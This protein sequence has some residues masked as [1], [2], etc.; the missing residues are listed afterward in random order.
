[1]SSLAKGVTRSSQDQVHDV[2]QSQVDVQED[3]VKPGGHCQGDG[4]V[5]PL[6]DV[7]DDVQ[8]LGAR[9][10]Q[11]EVRQD[12]QQG[13]GDSLREAQKMFSEIESSGSTNM[14]NISCDG[15]SVEQL[16]MMGVAELQCKVDLS[17]KNERKC[18]CDIGVSEVP[19]KKCTV[20]TVE[21]GVLCGGSGNGPSAA[22]LASP[23]VKRCKFAYTNGGPYNT[24][25]GGQASKIIQH[26]E[27]KVRGGIKTD[28]NIAHIS[29]SNFKTRTLQKENIDNLTPTKRKLIE[30]EN[31]H[32]LICN[33][34]SSTMNH[35]CWGR[36]G[37]VDSL[38]KQRKYVLTKEVN[39]LTHS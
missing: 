24:G 1:M 29:F 18:G 4:D 10:G 28:V 14:N 20:C 39:D 23:R 19:S 3:V 12:V 9:E 17:M 16:S 37:V 8:P 7:Q 36:E 21:T 38:A 15:M 33:F 32:S 26:F 31:I 6:V 13:G 35:L 34:E 22:I 11:G 2:Q 30:N 27:E 5:R 25:G